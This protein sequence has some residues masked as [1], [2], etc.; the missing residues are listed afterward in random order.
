MARESTDQAGSTSLE[1]TRGGTAASEHVEANE[2]V[3]SVALSGDTY[4][5]Q[6][7]QNSVESVERKSRSP[8]VLAEGTLEDFIDKHKYQ[9]LLQVSRQLMVQLTSTWTSGQAG[10]LMDKFEDLSKPLLEYK[11]KFLVLMRSIKTVAESVKSAMDSI[12]DGLGEVADEYRQRPPSSLATSINA[13]IICLIEVIRIYTAHME[14]GLP[15]IL[16]GYLYADYSPYS[17]QSCSF[18]LRWT[19]TKLTD[20]ASRLDSAKSNL[21]RVKR[22]G[23]LEIIASVAENVVTLNEVS[24]GNQ[25][26][27]SQVLSVVED[28]QQKLDAAAL[29][30]ERALL[31]SYCRFTEL[32]SISEIQALSSKR[33]PRTREWIINEMVSSITSEGKKNIVWLCGEAGTGKSVIS[34]CVANELADRGLLAAAFFCQHD[35]KTRDTVSA[36]IQTLG[37]ELAGKYPQYRKSLIKSLE[38]S[39]FMDNAAP[40]VGDLIRIFIINPFKDWPS[41]TP[42]M[43]VID[44]LDE[45]VDHSSVSDVL[46]AFDSLK[47]PIKLFLTSRP[48]VA[49]SPKGKKDF[50][51]GYFNVES[52]ENQQD[53]RIFAHDRL[54]EL[55]D[56]LASDG[57]VDVSPNEIEDMVTRLSEASN[58][59]FIWIT[60]VLGNVSDGDKYNVREEDTLGVVEEML[61]DPTATG[62]AKELLNRLEQCASMDLHSLYCR[63][64]YKAYPTDSAVNDFKVSIGFMLQAKVPLSLQ[65]VVFLITQCE[66]TA[67]LGRDYLS[68][69]D[70]HSQCCLSSKTCADGLHCCHSQASGR[71]QINAATSSLN[72]ALSCL[73]VLNSS[74]KAENK[75]YSLFRNMCGVDELAKNPTW[76]LADF[77]EVLQYSTVYWSSHFVDAFSKVSTDNQ[78]L[79]IQR[80]FEF[81]KT[82][83][84]YYLEA[85]LL[86]GKLNDVNEVVGSVVDAIAAFDSMESQYIQ[87]IFRDLKYIAFNFR[88]QLLVNPLQVYQ[89]PLVLV[90]QATEYH[91]A[92]HHLAPGT[93]TIGRDLH[94]GPL[95]LVGHK[96]SVQGV[97][98]AP[99]GQT[100]VSAGDKTIKIWSIV[101]GEC[102]KTF[103]GHTQSVYTVCLCHHDGQ[104]VA[105]G[106]RDKTCESRFHRMDKRLYPLHKTRLCKV[107]SLSSG[108]CTWTLEG[109]TKSV[110]SVALSPDGQT[111]VSGSPDN[112]IKLWSLR[113]GSCLKTFVNPGEA[114][115]MI[116]TVAVSSD[117][118]TIVSG[119]GSGSALDNAGDK[120]FAVKL[121]SIETG[122]CYQT[123]TH[124]SWIYSVAISRDAKTVLSSTEAGK[125]AKLWSVE[126]GECIKELLGHDGTVM[127]V[128]FSPDD[129]SVVTGSTDSTV[130]LWAVVSG[131]F[132][133]L[134]QLWSIQ[135]GDS[136]SLHGHTQEVLSVAVSMD[137]KRV[138]SGSADGTIKLW[139]METK[140]CLTTLKGHKTRV[141]SV[142]I[143]QDGRI[144]VSGSWDATVKIWAV[145][146]GACIHTMTGH[147]AWVDSVAISLDGLTAV[148]VSRQ[149]Q[150][151]LWSVS[152]GDCIKTISASSGVAQVGISPDGRIVV[153]G[154]RGKPVKLWL[155]ETGE[156][157]KTLDGP[158]DSVASVSKSLERPNGAGDVNSI[159]V[160]HAALFLCDSGPLLS[161]TP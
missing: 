30:K 1:Q 132:D 126:T 91:K 48:D 41:S 118:K 6:S 137:G 10:E 141:S 102:I 20:I 43:I 33:N 61:G 45:L 79:L 139:S 87:S 134:V 28:I 83:L 15:F 38:D 55:V 153:T 109:H 152:T 58:G 124:N 88:R 93:L 57:L 156:C 8:I 3:P 121:W 98:F 23:T 14:F 129:Q 60:L 127:S 133:K 99:D 56:S 146:T 2:L 116:L 19:I 95:T 158:Y 36:M 123:F 49:I 68:A 50:Q 81:S 29:E 12:V 72:T 24:L 145:E 82:K 7:Q 148:S 63:A 64:L 66:T 119:E 103:E 77:S 17:W 13:Y 27:T 78:E 113:T 86:L 157:F 107:W 106:S 161:F 53:I 143:S 89:Q 131:S 26:A 138:V 39:K 125:S 120:D 114:D 160:K 52:I 142:A 84:P 85:L 25:A 122:S 16:P 128:A 130:K 46:H 71:F 135:T 149:M 94:W 151:R 69:I 154:E 9:E 40:T 147:D 159:F 111:V 80:L 34:A 100:V 136:V 110:K 92:Y 54:T 18:S 4:P 101:T 31:R 42:C 70:C 117:G 105:S 90:P 62:T 47:K 75:A 144:V 108:A 112:T 73:G 150:I 59:L 96:S 32:H 155:V 104:T 11:D 65:A 44:A 35:N 140:T 97:C 37:Y 5:S 115:R 76:S 51:V 67:S 74:G 21:S 22:D